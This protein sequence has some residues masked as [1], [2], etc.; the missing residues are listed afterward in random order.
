MQAQILQLHTPLRFQQVIQAALEEALQLWQSDADR[1]NGLVILTDPAEPGWAWLKSLEESLLASLRTAL[2]TSLNQ[3]LEVVHRTIKTINIKL[4]PWKSRPADWLT[5]DCGVIPSLEICFLRCISGL[6]GMEW[7]RDQ[8]Y[9]YRSCFWLFGCNPWAW[10]YLDRVLGLGSYFQQVVR[11]PPLTAEEL[12]SWFTPVL[13][14][15]PLQGLS[16]QENAEAGL[17]SLGNCIHGDPKRGCS[18]GTGGAAATRRWNAHLGEAHFA[19][20]R[21]QKCG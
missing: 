16:N 4:L 6:D 1:C 5:G 15:D 14:A 19:K 13:A 18:T 8:V 12:A 17:G 3:N 9:R 21:P 7:L 20:A 10:M 11:L 2:K